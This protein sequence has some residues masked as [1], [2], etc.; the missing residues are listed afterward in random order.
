[1]L[2]ELERVLADDGFL[3]IV[4]IRRSWIGV[5]ER[6]FLAALTVEEA[7]RILLGSSIRPGTM[8]STLLWW[9][10]EA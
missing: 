9:R 6:E 7:R 2:N 1:M 8:T 4:D 5:L 3:F 10:Y